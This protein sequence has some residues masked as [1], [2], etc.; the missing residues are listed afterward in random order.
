[1]VN[2]EILAAEEA[3]GDFAAAGTAGTV[4]GMEPRR[5]WIQEVAC[6]MSGFWMSWAAARAGR[7]RVREWVRC[8]FAM[9]FFVTIW[10]EKI[11]GRLWQRRGG[12]GMDKWMDG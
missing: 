12:G 7:A 1:M 8:M 5:D 6:S 10:I 3:T 4:V 11:Q 9:F 2:A